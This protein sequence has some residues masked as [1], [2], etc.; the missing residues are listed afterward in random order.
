MREVLRASFAGVILGFAGGV[1]FAQVDP[2]AA[3]AAEPP[4]RAIPENYVT[5]GPL[6]RVVAKPG[7]ALIG[8]LRAAGAVAQEID[9]GSFV[10]LLVDAAPLGG[11]GGL[12]AKGAAIRD[13]WALIELNGFLLDTADP[14]ALAA[15][16]ATVPP[17]LVQ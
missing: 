9:Y 15:T 7:D 13:E 3:P 12:Q 4:S 6:H 14:A 5:A 2:A 8:A 17:A 16:L 10:L 1:S 11:I